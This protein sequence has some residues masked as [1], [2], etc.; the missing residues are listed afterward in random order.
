MDDAAFDRA[1]IAA[2]FQLAAEKGWRSVNVAAA[3]RAAGLALVRARERFPGRSVILLRFGRLADQSALAE[4]PSEG[5]VRDRLFDLLMR[6]I[7]VFQAHRAGVMALLRILP[8]EPPIALLLAL[9]TRRSMRWMLQAAGLSTGG[10][11]GELRVKGLV[12]VWLWTMRAWQSD[13]TED[14]SATMAALDAALRRA[15]QAAEFLGWSGRAPKSSDG[16]EPAA[17]PVE[18]SPDASP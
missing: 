3:A 7:D 1:L 5:P 13:E 12:A 10:V 16:A 14:L 8:T 4:A 18:P 2:A 6:R 15:E 9:A 17:G 11:R